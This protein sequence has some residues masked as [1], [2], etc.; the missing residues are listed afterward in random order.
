MKSS[1]VTRETIAAPLCALVMAIALFAP[2][3]PASGENSTE[4][5]PVKP[6]EE[7]YFREGTTLY[8]WRGC[9]T[10]PCPIQPGK[11]IVVQGT[12]KNDTDQE[13]GQRVSCTQ[14]LTRIFIGRTGKNT[15][16]LKESR[17]SS[18]SVGD[19]NSE[20]EE[21]KVEYLTLAPNSIIPLGKSTHPR[22]RGSLHGMLLMKPIGFAGND[23]VQQTLLPDC[24][25]SDDSKQFGEPTT[26]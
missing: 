14:T 11:P 17:Y 6:M 19:D 16:E 7:L 1:D 5:P 10:A 24:M 4:N 15:F 26:K 3:S 22:C 18:L 23:L 21:T 9:F 12:E 20:N 25:M 13:H 2:I 8:A